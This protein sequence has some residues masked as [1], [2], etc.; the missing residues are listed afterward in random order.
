MARIFER[1]EYLNMHS[2]EVGHDEC[3][4]RLNGLSFI[5][6]TTNVTRAFQ[7]PV[8]LA[9]FSSTFFSTVFYV[10]FW[11]ND[12]YYTSSAYGMVV[13]FCFGSFELT[14]CFL[15]DVLGLILSAH[16]VWA[17]C[18]TG[19]RCHRQLQLQ[20][21]LQPSLPCRTHFL[22]LKGTGN[23]LQNKPLQNIT[24]KTQFEVF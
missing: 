24:N 19:T 10:V 9:A 20:L 15:V 5:Y 8:I 16:L 2:V 23:I 7:M 4:R 17:Q 13:L 21:L 12:R 11:C 6:R 22:A 3:R 1:F 14:D 18:R